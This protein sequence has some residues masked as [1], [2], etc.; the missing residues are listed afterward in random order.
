MRY[1][2]FTNGIYW[3]KGIP[4]HENSNPR[5][6]LT[7]I[8][9]IAPA[10]RTRQ[11]D[12][13]MTMKR[14]HGRAPCR[15]LSLLAGH[16]LCVSLS[17]GCATADDTLS[18]SSSSMPKKRRVGIVGFGE[19]G[20]YLLDQIL[21]SENAHMSELAFVWN[22]SFAKVLSDDRILPHYRSSD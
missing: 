12:Y 10:Q 13:P 7:L 20:K 17:V 3:H 11:L 5:N 2:R 6:T 1:G 4:E 9:N 19:I 21:T 15:R 8:A 18:C 14:N 22:R 16:F